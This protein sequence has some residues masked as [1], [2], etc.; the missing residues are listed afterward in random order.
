MLKSMINPDLSGKHTI[1]ILTFLFFTFLSTNLFAQVTQ[2]WV[3]RYNGPV[4]GDDRPTLL[5]VDGIG[6]VYVTGSNVGSGTSWD[7]CTIKYPQT[8]I[9]IPPA[10]VLV[11]PPNGATSVVTNPLLDWDSAA[12]AESYRVQVSMDI[13][14]F[15]TVYDSSNITITQFQ[16]PVNGLLIDTIYFWRVNAS[17]SSG[18]SAW[19]S[20]WCLATIVTPPITPVLLSPP[21]GS[22][23]S[24]TPLLDWNDVNSATSY[25]LQVSEVSNFMTTVIDKISLTESSYQ[26]PCGILSDYV[27]Y[28]WRA[29][30]RNVGGWSPWVSAWNFT[31]Q[32]IGINHIAGEIP[33][34]Y[35]LYSNY[36]NPFNPTTK[37]KID[38]PKSSFVKLIVYDILGREIKTLVNEKLDAGRYEVEW[39]S[40]TGDASDYP[41]GIYY[42]KLIAD[43]Y[44]NVK[45]MIL[46]K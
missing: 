1:F 12:T 4:N 27:K 45:K 46:L 20:T 28:Y 10:P 2:E 32:P 29:R 35:Y 13:G 11:S 30:A 26:V 43:E 44:V 19:S 5:A 34:D 17:N 42:Y 8:T 14:F 33:I 22:I 40:L 9:Q 21:N 38:I 36:P 37:I 15:S 3:A 18:T 16:I 41:S 6:D 23:V 7:Y 25:R 31:T 39:P 24:T